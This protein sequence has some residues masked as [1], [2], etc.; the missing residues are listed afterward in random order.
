[1]VAGQSSQSPAATPPADTARRISAEDA[2]KLYEKGQTVVVDTR[3]EAAFKESHI[4]GAILIPVNEV[5]EKAKDLP[6]DK[7]IVTYCT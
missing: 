6:H 3:N 5:A 7:T 1:R 2:Y 4:K